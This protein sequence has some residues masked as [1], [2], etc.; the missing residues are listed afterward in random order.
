MNICVTGGAGY[1]GSFIVRQLVDAGHRVV[2]VDNLCKG[3]AS[4]VDARAQFVLAD[5]G[6]RTAMADLFRRQGVQAVVHMAAFSLVGES[7]TE[8]GNY[9]RNNFVAS[10]SLIEAMLS[11]GVKR[12][13]FSSTAATYGEPADQ[14]ITEE[15][16]TE[17]INPYGRAKLMVEQALAD[18]VQAFEIGAVSLRYFNVAGALP[19]GSL[20]EDHDPETHLI[21]L[22]L[23]AAAGRRDR[24]SIFG[25]DY[26]TPDGTCVRDYIHVLDL[27]DA[28]VRAIDAAQ[29][30]A[31][32]VYNLGNGDGFSVRQV[33]EAAQGVVGRTIPTAV[34]PR[35]A[36]DPPVLVASSAKIARELG[37]EPRRGL[38]QI[39]ADAWAW[40][41]SHPDGY[42]D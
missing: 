16:A 19:D 41:R 23:A 40:H 13:V 3:H 20:G 34:A 38:E 25:D 39:L 26:P 36:G 14:P 2:V 22:V 12:L 1:I 7:V 4:A 35:R 21:P 11:A 8:P 30:G 42:A 31:L 6:D 29:P 9:Y 10:L 5:C 27:A 24:I 18:F 17:P 32:K 15:F 28:H 37:W 33:I